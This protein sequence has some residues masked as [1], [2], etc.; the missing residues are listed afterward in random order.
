MIANRVGT[1]HFHSPVS[2]YLTA[3]L[4]SYPKALD[5]LMAVYTWVRRKS[6]RVV[7]FGESAGG[8]FAA[9]L[10][11]RCLT[12]GVP[13]PDGLVL[14]YPALNLNRSP[15]PSRALHL[16]DP[17]IPIRTY[18]DSFTCLPHNSS[19]IHLSVDT[20]LYAWT[21]RHSRRWRVL[22]WFVVT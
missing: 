2:S 21:D 8:N 20:F 6:A 18:Y 9:A 14:G 19:S 22:A 15:S 17:L 16:N 10:T 11:L 3:N 1:S 7:V 5:E 12:E 13:V 4:C